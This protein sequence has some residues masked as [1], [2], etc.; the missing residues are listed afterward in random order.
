MVGEQ[1]RLR[2]VL[3]SHPLK[4]SRDERGGLEVR[5]GVRLEGLLDPFSLE[6]GVVG[7]RRAPFADS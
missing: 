5:S 1:V 2:R 3:R 7:R 6:G 4:T